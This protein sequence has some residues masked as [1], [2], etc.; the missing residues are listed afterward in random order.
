LLNEADIIAPV[1]LHRWRLWKRRYNQ[2]AILA[3][4]VARLCGRPHDPRL[5][6]RKRATP[7]QGEMPS[8]KARRRNVLGAFRVPPE[9]TA[10][11]RGRN[12]LLVDAVFTTGATLNACARALKR[13]APPSRRAHPG[14]RCKSR[15]QRYMTK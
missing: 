5:L 4:G 12:I 15:L 8:A 6:M 11:V 7:S 2:A 3:E 13:R 1:P 10:Q 9:K 14:P